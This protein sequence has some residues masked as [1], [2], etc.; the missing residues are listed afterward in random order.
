L[1][2][3]KRLF[4]SKPAQEARVSAEASMMA[5]EV[6][7]MQPEFEEVDALSRVTVE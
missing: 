2:R 1:C 3:L 5:V 7:V 6:I 4:W